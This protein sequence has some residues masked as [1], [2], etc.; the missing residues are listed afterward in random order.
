IIGN[1]ESALTALTCTSSPGTIGFTS[2]CSNYTQVQ[3]VGKNSPNPGLSINLK[4]NDLN[5]FAP[6]IGLSWNV[7]WFGKGKTV[8]RS[9]YGINY[10]GALRNFI[11]VDSTA[12]TVPGIN[13]VGS[14]SS[15]VQYTP[16]TY[17]SLSNITLPIPLPAGTQTTVPFIIPTTDRTLTISTYN[18][19]VPY[20]QNWN[21][22]IQREVARNTTLEIRYLGT[23]GT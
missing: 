20:I 23:K 6:A 2:T 17:T 18:R 4:G 15:G 1:D 12:G 9:G 22:E 10:P 11:T 14:G 7:P 13:L 3:F 19:V 5:N 16:S 8:L 21:L